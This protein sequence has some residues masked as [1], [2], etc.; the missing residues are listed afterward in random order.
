[1]VHVDVR[2]VLVLRYI[3]MLVGVSA[4]AVENR[5]DALSI[6]WTNKPGILVATT[7]VCWECRHGRAHRWPGTRSGRAR[8]LQGIKGSDF[9]GTGWLTKLRRVEMNRPPI[10]FLP[11]TTQ[12]LLESHS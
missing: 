5:R 9:E 4:C 8:A 1:M 7:L 6:V 10:L 12:L 2:V 3:S 11:S